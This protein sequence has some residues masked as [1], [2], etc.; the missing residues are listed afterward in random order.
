MSYNLY[1]KT[2]IRFISNVLIYIFILYIIV[3]I[4]H[5]KKRKPDIICPLLVEIGKKI[6]QDIYINAARHKGL[7]FAI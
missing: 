7:S 1:N 4:I 3:S 5:V 6:F 2:Y